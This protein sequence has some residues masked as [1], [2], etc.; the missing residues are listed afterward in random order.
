M[1]SF[2]HGSKLDQAL[3]DSRSVDLL[4]PDVLGQVVE[5]VRLIGRQLDLVSL[6]EVK[7]F[8]WAV[9]GEVRGVETHRQEERFVVFFSQPLDRPLGPY[10]VGKIFFTVVRDGAELHE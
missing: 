8:L 4:P 7:I 10:A 6:V 9:V 1:K 3:V 2:L 5:V